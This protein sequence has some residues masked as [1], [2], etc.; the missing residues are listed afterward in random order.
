MTSCTNSSVKEPVWAN[1]TF[2][3]NGRTETFDVF[4]FLMFRD[5]KVV[6]FRQGTDT[7]KIRAMLEN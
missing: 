1:V 4:D 5:G 6:D 3:Q 2:T 7:A